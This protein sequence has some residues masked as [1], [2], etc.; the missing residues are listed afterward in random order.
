MLLQDRVADAAA[1]FGRIDPK[2]IHAAI[3]YDYLKAY[4]A[5]YSATPAEAR[6]LAEPY[7]AY[8]VERWRNLFA[9]VL[10]QVDEIDGKNAAVVDKEDRNQ[11]QTALADTAP[12]FE[13]AVENRAIT[14][15]YQNLAE[16]TVNYYL[17][18]IELLFSRN[19]FVQEVSGQFGII[20]PNETAVVPLGKGRGEKVIKLPEKYNNRNVMIEIL[21]EGVRHTQAYTP[22]SLNIQMMEGYGQLRVTQQDGG[23]PLARVYVKVY[24]K[25]KDGS[26]RFYKDGYTDLRGRFD[27]T[28][29]STNEIEQIEKFSIL[30][31][32]DDNG[33][34]V[35]EAVPPKM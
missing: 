13:F 30:L 27:Y 14:M 34:V 5:F 35:R 21:G 2:A 4:L 19:P 23:K 8:P 9:D 18:D 28:S 29:L 10:A 24:A 17:M 6:K 15:R 7:R 25:F 16:C 26:V 20:R 12:S 3:Q 22:H 32:S 31:M 11:K 1:W 33:A